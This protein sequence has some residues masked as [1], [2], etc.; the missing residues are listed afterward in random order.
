MLNVVVGVLLFFLFLSG[1]LRGGM[2]VLTD[3]LRVMLYVLVCVVVVFWGGVNRSA[4]CDVVFACFV[5]C[6]LLLLF[7]LGVCVINQFA[8][9]DVVFV[10]LLC[11]VC[12]F[13]CWGGMCD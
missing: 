9:W 10:C 13:F 1:V 11:F 12:L 3:L 4:A 6:S 7:L 5:C 2:C 8:A